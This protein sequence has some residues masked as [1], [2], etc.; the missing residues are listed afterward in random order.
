M[1]LINNS[2]SSR[3]A[4]VIYN[5]TTITT[6]EQMYKLIIEPLGNK[7]FDWGYIN[8]EKTKTAGVSKWTI[9]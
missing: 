6:N 3:T 1:I 8:K 4:K 5:G 2:K 7:K 9:T